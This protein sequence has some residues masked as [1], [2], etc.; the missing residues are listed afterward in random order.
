MLKKYN[1]LS[2]TKDTLDISSARAYIGLALLI[3]IH[4]LIHYIWLIK[5]NF[6]LW[7]D[8][9]AYFGKSIGMYYASRTSLITFA[10]AILG[11]GKYSQGI[12]PHRFILP[13]FSVPWYYIFGISADVAVMSCTTFLAI[14]IFSTYAIAARLFDRFTG[15]LAAFIL[16]VSPG[17]FTY[18]RRFSPEF[19]VTGMIALT[20]YLFLRSE[21][22]QNRL[23][24]ILFS[25]SFALCMFTKEMAFAF[26]P[27]L[28]IY[29]ALKMKIFHLFKKKYLVNNKNTLLNLLIALLA[30]GSI[31]FLVYWPHRLHI[32]D[33]IINAAFSNSTRMMWGM[34]ERY[35]IEGLTYYFKAILNFGF[36][37]FY[38]VW[39]VIGILS[40]LRGKSN[41]LVFLSFWLVTSYII[42]CTKQTRCPDYSMPLIIPLSVFAAY[43]VHNFFKNTTIRR[44]GTIFVVIWGMA[45]LLICSFPISGFPLWLDYRHIIVFPG[46]YRYHPINEDWKLEEIVGYLAENKNNIDHYNSVFVSANLG[47]FS[48]C[49]LGYV[50]TQEGAGLGFSCYGIPMQNIFYFDFIIVKDG[51]NL[52]DFYYT[53]QRDELVSELE[54][55]DD[56]VILSRSFSL[57]DGATVKIYK[58]KIKK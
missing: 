11:L 2:K 37:P 31:I 54:T 49:T 15:F 13:L 14:A 26:V 6:P 30:S 1:F 53:E 16:S 23:Y 35:T 17:F 45:Q 20:V 21:N 25:I 9:G 28:F 8:H 47:A 7:F 55:R 10:K 24:S 51:K 50:S 58:R 3:L 22:F 46:F 48:P 56:F 12:H 34:P 39:S 19:A 36:L 33:F 27:S 52:G 5:D 18:Y 38:L 43:G 4:V 40:C 42:L 41:A 44:I 29:A 57:P 32:L